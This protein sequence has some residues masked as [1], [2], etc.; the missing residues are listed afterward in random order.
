MGA[1]GSVASGGA[2]KAKTVVSAGA[3]KAKGAV[4]AGA[5]AATGAASAGA[6]R[7]TEAARTAEEAVS[8]ALEVAEDVVR[9]RA[10]LMIEKAVDRAMPRVKRYLRGEVIDPDM[11]PPVAAGA[12]ALVDAT[13]ADIRDLVRESFEETVLRRLDTPGIVA[14]RPS[15]SANPLRWVRALVLYTLF[16]HD[17]TTWAKLRDP[18]YWLFMLIGSVPVLGVRVGWWTLVFLLQDHRD[19]YQLCHFVITFKATLFFSAGLQAAVLGSALYTVCLENHNCES[20]APGSAPPG[21]EIDLLASLLQSAVCW[22]AMACL[23]WASPK[24]GYLLASPAPRTARMPKSATAWGSA[25]GSGARD[26]KQGARLSEAAISSASSSASSSANLAGLKG[27]RL[28][29]LLV[30]DTIVLLACVGW[31][32][33]TW[34]AE[35]HLADHI[36]Y[37]RLWH[38]R[39]LYALLAAPWA[40]LQLP[41][42]YTLVLHI[43]PT[44]YNAAGDVVRMASS[45]ERKAARERRLARW[46]AWSGASAKVSPDHDA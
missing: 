19:D 38:I 30:L 44:G 23:P 39:M 32:L 5:A 13:V 12:G 33:H 42:M 41:F 14:I 11:P 37:A 20:H 6:A 9:R 2:A 4:N 3:T 18:A 43:K 27:G 31:G 45:A 8:N 24:G 22:V 29:P 21:F 25:E 36:V 28:L 46:R 35:T 10:L 17:K 40:V 16:A 7:A 34:F 1:A 26:A 15:F